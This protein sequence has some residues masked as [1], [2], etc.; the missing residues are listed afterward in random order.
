LVRFNSLR[1]SDIAFNEDAYTAALTNLSKITRELKALVSAGKNVKISQPELERIK[2][3]TADLETEKESQK[4]LVER[5]R[6]ELKDESQ[7]WFAKCIEMGQ[8]GALPNLL[9]DY[10]FYLRATQTPA[11]AI[12]V[13][14]FIRL[15]HDLDTPGFSTIHGYNLVSFAL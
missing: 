3:R 12:F 4:Q 7:H 5:T 10:C 14:R 8:D 11:D 1:I 13:A 2:R 9:H 6:A 15:L